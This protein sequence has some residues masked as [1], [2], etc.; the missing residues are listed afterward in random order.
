MTSKP[1][2]DLNDVPAEAMSYVIETMNSYLEAAKDAVCCSDV[3]ADVCGDVDAAAPTLVAAYLQGAAVL[4]AAVIQGPAWQCLS[5]D[6]QMCCMHPCM[7]P[8]LK[9]LRPASDHAR[10]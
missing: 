8:L 1:L 7:S 3:L 9:T 5:P 10:E 2:H 6:G 4:H